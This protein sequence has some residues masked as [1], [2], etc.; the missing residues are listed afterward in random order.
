V[1]MAPGPEGDSVC[2]FVHGSNQ[3]EHRRGREQ[4]ANR[5]VEELLEADE[6]AEQEARPP[7]LCRR[8][9]RG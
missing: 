3:D 2:E 1:V 5:G 9:L 4:E 7:P 6:P 8:Q